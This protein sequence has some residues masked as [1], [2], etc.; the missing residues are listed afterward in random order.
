LAVYTSDHLAV[1]MSL[2]V[3]TGGYGWISRPA[4]GTSRFALVLRTGER[5]HHF[6]AA[7][8]AARLVPERVRTLAMFL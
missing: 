7:R 3:S 8:A 4:L 6:R 5:D 1:N 2:G